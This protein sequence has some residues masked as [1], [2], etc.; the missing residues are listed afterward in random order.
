MKRRNSNKQQSPGSGQPQRKAQKQEEATKVADPPVQ[1]FATSS[2]ELEP[3]AKRRRRSNYV[4]KEEGDAVREIPT[5]NLIFVCNSCKARMWD[6]IL[7]YTHQP[8][9]SL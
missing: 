4:P 3:V 7:D 6:Y 9:Q 2:S 1:S 8:S 5:M